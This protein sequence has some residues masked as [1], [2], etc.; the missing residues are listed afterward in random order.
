MLF[1]KDILETNFTENFAC[2]D[3]WRAVAYVLTAVTMEIAVFWFIALYIPDKV[4]RR[5][6]G[7]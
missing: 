7:E 2:F 6:G 3:V 1:R 4:N 5:F